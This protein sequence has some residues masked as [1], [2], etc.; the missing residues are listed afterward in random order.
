MNKLN[1]KQKRFCEEYLKDMNGTQAAIRAG[2]SEKTA[3]SIANENLTK[4]DIQTYIKELQADVQKR[5][6]ISIDEIVQ[7]LIEIKNRCMQNVPVMTY[8]K[9][10]K[11]YVQV[12]DEN[13]RGIWKFDAAGALK[14]L[15][16]LMKHLGGYNADNQQ[17]QS[18][19]T[20]N[21][22]GFESAE[23]FT[24]YFLKMIGK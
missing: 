8:D 10:K 11:D 16:L 15:D 18:T 14:A 20:N 22:N 21:I 9:V 13:G 17:K 23:A 4:P 1:D 5:N 19:I 12:Q 24:E 3:K 7:N 2:Y 6:E